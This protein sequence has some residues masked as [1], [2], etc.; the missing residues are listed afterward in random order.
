MRKVKLLFDVEQL[1][2]D[3]LKGTGIVRVCDELLRGLNTIPD[4]D[5]FP[6]IT[7]ERGN[8][9]VYLKEKGLYDIFKDNL[10]DEP[11]PQYK[12]ETIKRVDEEY[13]RKLNQ[14]EFYTN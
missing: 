7:S 3:G 11:R 6:V 4:I 5:V 14:W 9:D 13:L 8:F 12:Q 2:V 1:A 10:F